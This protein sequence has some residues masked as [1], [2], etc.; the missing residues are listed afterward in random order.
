MS[1]GSLDIMHKFRKGSEDLRLQR[2]GRPMNNKLDIDRVVQ[3]LRTEFYDRRN[4]EDT[5]VSG[6][7]APEIEL[8]NCVSRW[9]EKH[10]HPS[11]WRGNGHGYVYL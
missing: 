7:D 6:F 4:D 10:S 1:A 5:D 11:A 8:S 3:E 9:V 2:C